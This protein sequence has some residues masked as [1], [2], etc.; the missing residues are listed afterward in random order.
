MQNRIGIKTIDAKLMTI[1]VHSP[2]RCYFQIRNAISLFRK[3][4]IP[5][6]FAVK[7]VLSVILSRLI[8]LIM[9]EKRRD[10]LNAYFSGLYD[11]LIGVSG[12]K[13]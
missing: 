5:I 13:D 12:P 2:R 10:Y 1:H 8:L 9:V 3:S 11:G 7:E 6:A 4:H